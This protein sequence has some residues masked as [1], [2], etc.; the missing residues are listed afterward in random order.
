MLADVTLKLIFCFGHK[1]A[2][3]PLL[4]KSPASKFVEVSPGVCLVEQVLEERA[5]VELTFEVGQ[6][7]RHLASKSFYLCWFGWKS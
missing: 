6:N 4:K 7:D 2:V 1:K 3:I 5:L